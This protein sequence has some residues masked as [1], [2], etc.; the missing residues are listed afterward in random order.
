MLLTK[1]I[2]RGEL[3]ELHRVRAQSLSWFLGHT[4]HHSVRTFMTSFLKCGLFYVTATCFMNF[5]GGYN[6]EF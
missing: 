6:I 1:A 5:E 4:G 2:E 3:F